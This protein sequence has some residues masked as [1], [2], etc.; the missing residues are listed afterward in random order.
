[1]CLGLVSRILYRLRTLAEQLP[2]D[3]STFALLAPLLNVIIFKG[4][5]AVDED[6]EEDALE[7]LT[8]TLDFIKFHAAECKYFVFPDSYQPDCGLVSDPVYPRI[9]VLEGLVHIIARQ[10]KLSREAVAVLVEVGEALHESSTR[11]EQD[12]LLRHTKAQEVY[13]RNA[14]LQA[15]Q[16]FDLTDIEWS[17]ELFIACHDDDVQNGRLARQLCDENDLEIPEKYISSLIP[18]F[19]EDSL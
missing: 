1:M 4:G 9:D 16:P 3:A 13:V 14:V 10:P 2:L 7:Q 8:L 17:P 6:N 12:T 5:L 15:L 11:E 19:G 18:L